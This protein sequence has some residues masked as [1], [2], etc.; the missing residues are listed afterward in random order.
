MQDD[1]YILKSAA[2]CFE[3]LKGLIDEMQPLKT[4]S[5]KDLSEKFSD[6]EA[7]K[8]V[9]VVRTLCKYDFLE[10][11]I[12]RRTF[13]VGDSFLFL[14]HRYLTALANVVNDVQKKVER[15]KSDVEPLI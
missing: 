7:Q 12:Q 10:S 11:D 1:K 2:D 5:Y 15:F 6:I 4:Y 13:K 9:R 3:V 8:L 14:S